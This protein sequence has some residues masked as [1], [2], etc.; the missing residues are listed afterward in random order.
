MADFSNIPII[1]ASGSPRRKDFLKTL[2]S[3]FQIIPADIEENM[4]RDLPSEQLAVLISEE[5]ALVVA[6]KYHDAIV[7]GADTLVV[8]NN[9][10]LSKP[11]NEVE[12]DEMLKLLSNNKQTVITGMALIY[13][14][15][16]YSFF[17][18][19]DLDF[20]PLPD[21]YIKQYIKSGEP[22]DKSGGYGIQSMNNQ[23]VKKITGDITNVM[24]FPI[25]KFK[26]EFAYFKNLIINNYN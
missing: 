19:T 12:A 6:K 16:C 18:K 7:I 20:Y 21:D 23:F 13:K 25:E 17:D 11:T 9:I 8:C 24:G 26:V 2:I 5:K 22:F 3:E 1:L 14:D 4:Q 15:I 10:L